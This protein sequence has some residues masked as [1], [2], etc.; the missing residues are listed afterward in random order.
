MELVKIRFV[1]MVPIVLGVMTCLIRDAD[2]LERLWPQY[3]ES[4]FSIA[5]EIPEPKDTRGGVVAA[6]LDGDDRPDFLIS[7]PGHLAAYANDGKKLWVLDV[8]IRVAAKSEKNGL[9]GHHGPGVQA[10]DVDDDGDVEVLFLT[11]DSVVHAVNGATGEEE[12][13]ALPLVPDDAERWE[14]SVIA[15]FRGTGDRDLLLQATNRKGFRMGKHIAAYAI[16]DLAAGILDPLWLRDDF[17]GCAHSGARVTDLD[18]DGRDEVIGGTIVSHRGRVLIRIPE[19]G[20]GAHLDA[21]YAADV[22]P[23][24]PGFEVVALEERKPNRVFVY[25]LGGLLWETHYEHREPQ[26]AAIGEFDAQRP[27]L[28]IWCRSRYDMSQKPFVFDANGK[29]IAE[30]KLNEVKPKKWTD[31]GVEVI[32]T[33]DWT[34]DRAQLMV[35]KERHESGDVALIEPMTGKFVKRIKSRADRLYVADVSG[36]WREEII[37]LKGT[38]LMIYFNSDRNPNPGRDRLWLTS[39]YKRSKMTWNYYNP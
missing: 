4:P 23:E 17:L 34:G 25:G 39:A 30:Y 37:V 18:E 12:W 31:S 3:A 9:P 21:V 13:S 19:L 24:F 20:K 36:D 32:N 28:E 27:G 1:R 15:N 26:N 29:K 2:G 11:E 7:V 5:L 10:G 16:P 22:R 14:H 35:A 6:D 33:I 38:K 8:P